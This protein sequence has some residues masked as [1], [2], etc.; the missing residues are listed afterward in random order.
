MHDL[1]GGMSPDLVYAR[2]IE[3]AAFRRIAEDIAAR[4]D[5]ASLMVARGVGPPPGLSHLYPDVMDRVTPEVL[6]R[7]AATLFRPP[8]V[9]DLSHV[10]PIRV[11]MSDAIRAV[12]ERLGALAGS[13]ARY[14]SVCGAE[15][16]PIANG[17]RRFDAHRI[18][19]RDHVRSPTARHAPSPAPRH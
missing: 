14:C 19:P 15:W 12:E 1:L 2:S 3:L 5:A 4:I 6:A 7:T 18:A 11:S 8:P 10:A 9:V 17:R 13:D 16:R